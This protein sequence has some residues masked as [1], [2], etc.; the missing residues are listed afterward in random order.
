M[1]SIKILLL[2]LL[3]LF[4]LLA[5]GETQYYS[6]RDLPQVTSD[7]WTQTYQ[8]YGRTIDVDVEIEIPSADTA[9][10]LL[11]RYASP[12]DEER[13]QTLEKL[14]EAAMK[15]DKVND[16]NFVSNSFVTGYSHAV[17]PLWG[18]TRDDED[19]DYATMSWDSHLLTDYSMDEAYAEDNDLLLGDAVN[20]AKE[21]VKNLFPCDDIK[22]TNAAVFDRSF[23]R[24]SKEK[25]SK[26]GYY[27]IEMHQVLR[28][29]PFMASLHGAF[30]NEVIGDEKHWLHCRG[31]AIAEVWDE[32]AYDLTYWFYEE[33]GILYQDIPL[34]PFDGLKYQIEELIY[35]G[36]IRDIDTVTL[37]YVQFDTE[38]SDEYALVP[39]WVIWC[40]Y[41]V[42]GPEVEREGELYSDGCLEDAQSYRPI[43]INAQTGKIIDPE[44]N[45]I[46]RCMMPEIVTWN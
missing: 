23:Y 4:P 17:P 18:T 15:E 39:A 45:E 33:S 8:A 34:L 38:N 16:Y 29:I 43:I 36:Y 14:C 19:Y 11:V 6:I 44:S 46:G 25:I 42:G 21:Q 1:K 41:Q 7:R 28:N 22:F 32:N 2:I 5:C 13:A 40:E 10:V 9:P 30:T 31:L 20:I 12:I 27:H 24:K 37:G 35:S 26:K 3:L